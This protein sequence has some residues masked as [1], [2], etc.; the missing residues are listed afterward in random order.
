MSMHTHE[1]AYSPPLLPGRAPSRTRAGGAHTHVS[2][3]LKWKRC[4]RPRKVTKD[5]GGKLR[6]VTS[7]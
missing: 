7:Q 6:V 2:A 5:R 4:R 1:H 3:T